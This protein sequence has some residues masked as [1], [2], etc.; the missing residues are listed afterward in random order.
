MTAI[1]QPRIVHAN[2][3][4]HICQPL[5]LTIASTTVLTPADHPIARDTHV[6][7]VA[8]NTDDQGV[9]TITW[10]KLMDATKTSPIC[11]N[12]IKLIQTGLPEEMKDWPKELTSYFPY[13]RDLMET[14]GL[15]RCGG[16]TFIPA[17]LRQEA[18]NIL[19]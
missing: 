2:E 15:I 18:I 14:E 8:A 7:I 17:D 9:T 5:P 4:L 6:P 10:P 1:A 11:Q 3:A 12:L 16:G 19:H 13:R